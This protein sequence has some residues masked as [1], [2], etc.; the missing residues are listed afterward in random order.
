MTTTF[1]SCFAEQ[2]QSFIHYR[3]ALGYAQS[4]ALKSNLKK[5]DRYLPKTWDN[6]EFPVSFFLEFKKSLT[7]SPRTQNDTLSCAKRFFDYMVRIDQASYNPFLN[8]PPE[9]EHAFIP[10]IF[11]RKETDA[12]LRAVIRHI[13]P[14]ETHFFKDMMVY[15]AILLLA[16]CGMRISEPF[17]LHLTHYRPDDLTLYIEKTKFGKDRLIAIPQTVTT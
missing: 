5:L 7:G 13:R 17:R 15:T 6:K 14:D 9:K 11:S 10:F 12:L 1:E 2:L 8:I 16:R 3:Y 4:S